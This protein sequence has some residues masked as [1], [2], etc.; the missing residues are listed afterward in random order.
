VSRPGPPARSE[1][2]LIGG[3]SGVGKSTVAFE[4]VAQLT[5][6][7]VPH[8][9]IEGD[10]L[11]LA[12]PPPWEHGLAERNL[13]AMWGNYRALGYRRLVYTNVVSVCSADS[14]CAAMGDDPRRIGVL[15]TAAD[16]ETATRLVGREIGS[17]LPAQLVRSRDRAAE[18]DA[19]APDWVV[20]VTTDHRSVIDIAR[21]V[22]AIT[23]WLDP[24][25]RSGAETLL[26]APEGGLD[27]RGVGRSHPGDDRAQ[28]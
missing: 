24:V 6:A 23:G 7:R 11:D 4:I 13:A 22:I 1:I 27:A 20:R 8:A 2:L 28:G 15:L 10:N 17:T 5:E 21:E 18:L 9:A 3:R 12:W 14:L 25:G 26:Q 19:Q 16:D